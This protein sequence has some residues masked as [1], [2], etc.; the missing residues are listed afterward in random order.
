MR[1]ASRIS[2]VNRRWGVILAGGDGVR[3]QPLTRI[4]CGD[5]RPKQF[6]PLL[7][8]RTL[9]ART[10]NRIA[11]IIE[12]EQTV[13]ALTRTHE[14]YYSRALETIPSTRKV[15]QPANRG[16]LPAILWSLLRVVRADEEALVAFLPSDH[17][18][19]NEPAF[20]SALSSAFAFVQTHRDRV[21]LLGASADRPEREYGWIEPGG[22]MTHGFFRVKHFWEKPSHE[23]AQHL[24]ERNCLWNTFVM[25]GSASAFLSMARRAVPNIVAAFEEILSGAGIPEEQRMREFYRNLAPADFSRDVL[26]ASTEAL[27][28]SDCGE[29]GWNDLGDPGRFVAALRQD[30]MAIPEGLTVFCNECRGRQSTAHGALIAEKAMAPAQPILQEILP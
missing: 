13:F 23:T 20:V 18:I 1:Y 8:G 7:G 26:S 5:S 24:L 29:I 30:G 10:Q 11:G 19:A 9:L 25:V 22:A 14:Q 6:C 4:A 28:V 16:T 12:P 21:V 2:Q 27:V 3:L 17:Y 15:E